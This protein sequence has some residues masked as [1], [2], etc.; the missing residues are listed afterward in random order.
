MIY[1]RHWGKITSMEI[2]LAK[3]RQKQIVNILEMNRLL[4]GD[5]EKLKQELIQITLFIKN[6]KSS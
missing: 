2:Y 3:N 6:Q 4:E 1:I 5:V